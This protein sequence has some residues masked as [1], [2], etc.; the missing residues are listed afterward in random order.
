MSDGRVREMEYILGISAHHSISLAA[1]F[2]LLTLATIHAIQALERN[3]SGVIYGRGIN[4]LTSTPRRPRILLLL[5]S[6]LE[7]SIRPK[8]TSILRVHC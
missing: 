8:Y 3:S 6:L 5:L 1:F 4:N 7:R 2:T